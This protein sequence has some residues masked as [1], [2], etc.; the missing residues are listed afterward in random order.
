MQTTEFLHGSGKMVAMGCPSSREALPTYIYSHLNYILAMSQVK[1]VT[2][3]DMASGFEDTVR[4]K[5]FTL[6]R[7]TV[8]KFSH[9]KSF[10]ER[11]CSCQRASDFR[12]LNLQPCSK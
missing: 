3:R 8:C 9:K 11:I 2:L 12:Q 6:R 4:I 10:Y 7:V 1:C 5:G